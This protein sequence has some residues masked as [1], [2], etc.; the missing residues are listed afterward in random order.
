MHFPDPAAMEFCRLDRNVVDELATLEA[1]CFTLPWSKEQLANAFGVPHFAAFGLRAP[2]R[3][4]S[5]TGDD[6]PLVAYLSVY[7]NPDELEILNLAVAPAWRGRGHGARLLRLVLRMAACMG[8]RRAVLE[9]RSGNIPA[10]ALY[11]GQGFVQVGRRRGYYRDSGEDA[12]VLELSLR[13][14]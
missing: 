2:L 11:K 4:G 12:L 7:H 13:R 14:A 9:V 6:A 8:V 5:G 10:L 3:K 1:Q